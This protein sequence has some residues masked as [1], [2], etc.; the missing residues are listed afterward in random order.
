MESKVIENVEVITEDHV[1][2][3]KLPS[4]GKRPTVQINAKEAQ[5]FH[6]NEIL[7]YPTNPH[8]FIHHED[9]GDRLSLRQSPQA[10]AEDEHIVVRGSDHGRTMTQEVVNA[11]PVEDDAISASSIMIVMR[12][13]QHQDPSIG[14]GSTDHNP[15]ILA[16]VPS[17]GD[18]LEKPPIL[19]TL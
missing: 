13:E 9:T 15:F 7:P 18:G 8:T 12:E 11:R 10:A 5:L 17:E 19:G 14:I 4:R 2:N 1:A 16:D 3:V 6:S